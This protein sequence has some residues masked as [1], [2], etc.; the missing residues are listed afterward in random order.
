MR[1]MQVEDIPG[2][3]EELVGLGCEVCAVGRGY[4]IG[5]ADLKPAEYDRIEHELHA[6][7]E[8]YG[9]RD[10]FMQEIASHL[11]TIGRYEE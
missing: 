8:R 10:H 2:F 9:Y 1:T 11:R 7:L 3:V 4:V 5:D 6:L